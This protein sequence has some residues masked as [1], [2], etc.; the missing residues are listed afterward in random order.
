MFLATGF[1]GTTWKKWYYIEPLLVKQECS[2]M[3]S[4][5]NLR[6]LSRFP[7]P[8]GSSQ[9][10][11]AYFKNIPL[12]ILL[13]FINIMKQFSFFLSFSS[14]PVGVATSNSN[15]YRLWTHVCY[16]MFGFLVDELAIVFCLPSLITIPSEG[17]LREPACPLHQCTRWAA[18]LAASGSQLLGFVRAVKVRSICNQSRVIYLLHHNETE[19]YT[20]KS[21]C[22][23]RVSGSRASARNNSSLFLSSP[24][25][26]YGRWNLVNCRLSSW[27]SI[28]VLL[29]S[30][31]SFLIAALSA[32]VN[33]AQG[34]SARRS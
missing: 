13:L 31:S 5:R 28:S 20:F 24:T 32:G 22:N 7:N 15:V 19:T 4:S 8:L 10:P 2:R 30:F 23:V 27:T 6:W 26:H 14:Q 29:N 25:L 21:Q 9:L 34:L 18:R 1:T 33:L 17:Q 12:F 11:N 16:F 3:K